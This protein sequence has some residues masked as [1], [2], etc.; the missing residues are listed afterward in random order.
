MDR[1]V[2]PFHRRHVGP[3]HEQ[4]ARMCT[5]IGCDD[6]DAM[7]DRIVPASIRRAGTGELPEGAD[8]AAALRRLR[9]MAGRNRVLRSYLG[10]GYHGCVVPPVIQRNVLENPGWY[11]PYTPYQAE[12]AQGRLEML[13]HFQTLVAELT[14]LPI[15]NAS[16]LDESTAAAEA[17]TMARACVDRGRRATC[18]VDTSCH[19]QTVDVLRTRAEPLGI[20]LI[21][22]DHRDVHLD[23]DVFAAIVQYPGTEGGIVDYAPFAERVRAIGAL[24]VCAADP[25]ALL[26]LRPPAEWGADI[27][28]GNSQRFGVPMGYGGPHAAFIACGEAFKRQLPGRLVGLSRDRH[29]REA[30]RLALQTR[31]QHIRRERATSNICT[32]QALLANMAAMYAIWHGPEGLAAIAERVH[33]RTTVLAA[34]LTGL[35][36][37]VGDAPFFDTLRVEVDDRTASEVLAAA[38]SRGINLRPL[39]DGAIGVALDET[40]GP[41][42]VRDVWAAFNGGRDVDFDH[43]FIAA[44][45]GDRIDPALRRTG[46]FLTQEIFHRHHSE[47][48]MMRYLKRLEN[49]DLSL[50]HSMIP[51]GSCTMKLNPAAAMM[52]VTWDA[53]AAI[54]PFAPLDQ[55]EGYQ[56]LFQ[57]L[58]RWLIAITGLDSCS[59][60]PNSGAQGEFA[61]L[62]AIRAWHRSRGESD[63][64]VCLIPRSAHGTNPASAVMAGMRVVVVDCDDQGNI[65]VEDLRAKCAEHA[66]HLAA[67]MVTYPSTHGVFETAIVDVCR[68]VHEHGGQ[69]YLD[70]ANLNA[71][72][73]VTSVDAIG[74]D[75]CHINLHKTFAIPHGGGGPGM[76][77]ICVRRHL[78]PFLPKHPVVRLPG[79]HLQGAVAA[80]P[81]GSALILTISWM[82]I[83][84]MGRRGLERATAVAMC[85][86]NYLAKRLGPHFPVLYKG[87]DGFVAHECVLDC[88]DLP[89]EAG[90]DVEDIAKR[91]IDYGFHAPTV[92]FPVPGTVMIE[93]TESEDLEEL[94][95]F[96]EAM[97][98]IRGEI[99][100]IASGEADRENNLLKNAPH[101]AEDLCR[102]DP[103]L[104]YS[105]E[106]AAY[107]CA[108]LREAKYWPPVSRIDAAYGDRNLV[109]TCPPVEAHVVEGRRAHPE[110]RM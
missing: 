21:V 23:D 47:S 46:E 51:L 86:A 94:D 69:V 83:A 101:A 43:D 100:E 96:C 82:Y 98:A 109:C 105:R 56:L 57:Q 77:P 48:A 107:G 93:P 70:G 75:V 79:E 60:Q 25:L 95:R 78:A 6:L 84:M 65:D 58:E 11:T 12:I 17:M 38:A 3:D 30:Y 2:H 9:E 55:T 4:V 45:C 108:W 26:L 63:R 15:A 14:G 72:V 66:T 35:G 54:H 81:W 27:C 24:T 8:E 62:L 20:R 97:I 67:L 49:R 13:F 87:A 59:L 104:P 1:T 61:G 106:R 29:G 40:V 52:P 39:G 10:M 34:G 76:G 16:L 18:F 99:D 22:G 33:F 44:G 53:F 80:A 7:V 36:C 19:P 64:D 28:V 103:D 32:A 37:R 102:D 89:K 90:V 50:V 31:E 85:S 42:D 110:I 91:L 88:R 73:G 5:A 41:D 92:S 74:A 68:C 71:M